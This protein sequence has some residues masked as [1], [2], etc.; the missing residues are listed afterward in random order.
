MGVKE[1][2][3][4]ALTKN[5]GR[6]LSGEELSNSLGVS[7]SAVWKAIKS[8]RHEGYTIEAVTNKGYLLMEESWCITEDLLKSALPQKYKNIGL[9][10]FDTIDST[11]TYAKNLAISGAL[12]GTVV[13][14]HQQT[15]GKGRL[16]RSFHSP[17]EGIY[18]SVIIKPTFD[19]SKSVLATSAAAVAVTD[20]IEEVCGEI[21]GIKW[22]NDVYLNGLKV[23]GILCE[24][25]MNF[26]TGQIDSIV[27]GI[28]INTTIK[29]FPAELSGIAGAISGDYSRAALAAAVISKTLDIMDSIEDRVFIKAYKERSIV[30]GKTVNV[31]KGAY[32]INPDDELPSQPARVIDIDDNGGLVVLYS[33]GSKET[34]ISGEISVRL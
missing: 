30:I 19:I 15:G 17:K 18:L 24:G 14:A 9:H 3:L 16:G 32:R 33:D 6:F 12:H 20:A 8:L 34:L 10:V 28:G 13:M 1:S 5:K 25:I 31:F 4:D 2:V 21:T 29:G 23:C 7:R 27:M 22:V 11:N 26:E